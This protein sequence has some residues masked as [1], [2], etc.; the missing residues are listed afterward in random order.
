MDSLEANGGQS[1]GRNYVESSTP[2]GVR[3]KPTVGDRTTA[4]ADVCRTASCE[5]GGELGEDGTARNG[6]LGRAY[7]V[8]HQLA[9]DGNKQTHA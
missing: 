5:A 6:I 4:R 1:D 7:A 3:G 9:T 8:L 2:A